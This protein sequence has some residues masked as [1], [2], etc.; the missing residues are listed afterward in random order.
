[1]PKDPSAKIPT[2]L[3]HASITFLYQ[4]ALEERILVSQHQTLVGRGAMAC[5]Q[6]LNGFLLQL[7]GALQLFNIFCAAFSERRLGLSIALLALLGGGIYLFIRLAG[8]S[9]VYAMANTEGTQKKH[10]GFRPP[11]RFCCC[12]FSGGL[13]CSWSGRRSWSS[14]ASGDDE[15]ENEDRS[16]GAGASTG[17]GPDP[18]AGATAE[19]S[20]NSTLAT[21]ADV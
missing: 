15:A 13:S 18:F 11:F 1:M 10:T 3:I 20:S 16:P 17:A 6:G 8:G 19:W 2:N 5:L 9:G 4:Y 12:G 14:P 21:E 7:D